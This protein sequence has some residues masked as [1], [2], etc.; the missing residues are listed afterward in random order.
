[1]AFEVVWTDGSLEDFESIIDYLVENWSDKIASEF[2]EI[3]IDHLKMISDA[4]FMGIASSKENNVRKLLITK[5][6][7]LYYRVEKHK[8]VLLGFFDTRMN[9]NKNNFE[10]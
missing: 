3:L 10:R 5:H 9:P 8:I 2:N 1:M 4:P 6:N 7:A